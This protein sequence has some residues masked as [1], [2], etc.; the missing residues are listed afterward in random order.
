MS[1]C[2]ASETGFF[3]RR[4]CSPATFVV[5]PSPLE[6]VALS[7]DDSDFR[8]AG[9]AEFSHSTSQSPSHSIIGESIALSD[10]SA[11]GQYLPPSTDVAGPRLAV[12]GCGRSRDRH[13]P[14]RR[15]HCSCRR[16]RQWHQSHVGWSALCRS[17][18]QPAECRGTI[19]RI[20]RRSGGRSRRLPRGARRGD[21][22]S[23]EPAPGLG[24]R[25]NR[26]PPRPHGATSNRSI[27]HGGCRRVR[28]HRRVGC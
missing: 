23:V 10:R 7:D 12:R 16:W 14:R 11:C 9:L 28:R 18:R 4:H 27:R 20:T 5:R 6:S 3:C 26:T 13:R 22:R 19:Y 15:S 2:P 1:D 21:A 24:C 25:A 8:L 17:G